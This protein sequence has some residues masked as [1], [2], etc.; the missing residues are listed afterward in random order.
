MIYFTAHTFKCVCHCR[1]VMF[2][3]LGMYNF[4][5]LLT[6]CFP[7]WPSSDFIRWKLYRSS[8]EK[9][10][11]GRFLFYF[12]TS[13]SSQNL[14]KTVTFWTLLLPTL[15]TKFRL[16]K[17]KNKKESALYFILLNF[18]FI[19]SNFAIRILSVGETRRQQSS[20]KIL[21]GIR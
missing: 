4:G 1:R 3:V 14:V 10:N 19:F 5:T 15:L 16:Q 9:W 7:N 21:F 17:F 11:R 2:R 13:E 18:I 12:W 6:S 8:A 20:S